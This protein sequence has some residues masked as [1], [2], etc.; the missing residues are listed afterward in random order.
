MK[1]SRKWL[2]HYVDLGGRTDAAL[3]EAMT[4]IG[5][6][7]EGVENRGAPALERVVVGEVKTR[8]QHPNA[9]RLSVCTVDVGDGRLR[10]IVCGAKNF[11]EG[12]R[13]FVALPGAKV[14]DP[15]GQ[16]FAI[17]ESKL[18]GV[19][20]QGMMCSARELGLGV[21]HQGLLILGN[22]P[23]V[24][25]AFNAVMPPP[26]TV[27][28]LEIT[29]NR[30]DCLCHVGV[31]RE[32]AA[33]WGKEL[34]YPEVVASATDPNRNP[35]ENLVSSIRVEA[36]EQCPLYYGFSIR[37]VKI[38]PSPEWL[39]QALEAVGLRPIN[40]VVDVTNYVLME[41]GQP[42]HAFDAGKIRGGQL[43]VRQARAGE[44]LTTLDGKLRELQ[45]SMTVIADAERALVVAGVMGS[46][47]AEVDNATTD[48]LLEAAFF[49]ASF[50]RKTSRR[51]GLSTDSSYRFERGVD[52]NNTAFAALRA[53]DLILATAGGRLAGQP[54]QVGTPS[55]AAC[56]IEMK[57]QFIRDSLGFGPDDRTIER[58][59]SA[60]ELEVKVGRAETGEEQWAVAVPSFRRDLERPADLVEEFLRIYGTDKIPE[61]PVRV[62]TDQYRRDPVAVFQDEAALYLTGRQFHECMMYSL[63]S[64]QEVLH[65]Y[66][67]AIAETL[68]LANPL[69]ADQSH[70][71]PTLLAG[72]LDSLKLNL[73]RRTGATRLFERGRVFRE[74]NGRVYELVSVA[75]LIYLDPARRDWKPREPA[76]FFRCKNLVEGLLDLAGVPMAERTPQPV[77]GEDNWQDGQTAR[78]GEFVR[79]GYEAKLG[80]M[81]PQR[82]REW[83]IPGLVYAGGI[84]VKPEYLQ[85]QRGHP[86]FA[87]FSMYP[88]VE[89]D[90]ALV[91]EAEAQA[92]NVRQRLEAAAREAGGTAAPVEAVRVFDVYQGQGLP[93]GKK[94]LAFTLLFRS[95]ERTLKDEEVNPVFERIQKTMTTGTGWT[96][97]GG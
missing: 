16:W 79:D 85:G 55:P 74:Y 69:T 36:E 52:A 1:I 8:A 18:R 77:A 35:A 13:V 83:D 66:G 88:A 67:H 58:V 51:L 4:L 5:F 92:E 56:E 46:I 91:V 48:I 11:Q 20:S 3:E 73:S 78:V 28:D 84:I 42:L 65:W 96:V 27:F 22:R 25:A 44:P 54:I 38:G 95:F 37:G 15:E 75:F 94:S 39:K 61:S 34:R 53:V 12:D 70:L 90:L 86:R 89:K 63:R 43:V 14:R 68:R 19:E 64:E 31:A 33:Y 17:Q 47:D 10:N 71:R 49:R 80:L 6:E 32:L 23:E 81:N 72:L 45:P 57:P 93:E 87:P 62:R 59:L 82:T 21:D 41:L 97:R 29:P 60:L 50:I 2:E 7:V 40:N 76:D 26:D 30:P 24:G 9:D